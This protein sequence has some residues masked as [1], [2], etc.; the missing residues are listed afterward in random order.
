RRQKTTRRRRGRRHNRLALDTRGEI[1]R[2]ARG[3]EMVRQ[4]T[5]GRRKFMGIAAAGAAGLLTPA[6]AGGR[7]AAADGRLAARSAQPADV[8]LIVLNA[9]VYTVDPTLPRAD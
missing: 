4:R 6:W 9:R 8:D 2:R 3:P 7:L 1:I 5:P